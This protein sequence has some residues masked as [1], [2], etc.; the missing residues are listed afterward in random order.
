MR[1]LFS[2]KVTNTLLQ[3]LAEAR[4]YFI[5]LSYQIPNTS[6]YKTCALKRDTS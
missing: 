1:N 2:V 3:L 4:S 6:V 5:R